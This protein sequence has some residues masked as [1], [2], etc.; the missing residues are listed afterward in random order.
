[1]DS[2]DLLHR[3]VIDLNR[4]VIGDLAVKF[5]LLHFFGFCQ[6]RHFDH[7]T[8]DRKSLD[9]DFFAEEV[10]GNIRPIFPDG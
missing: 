5:L 10:I 7:I 4:V 2:I 8:I 3:P 9:S 1:M 6:K